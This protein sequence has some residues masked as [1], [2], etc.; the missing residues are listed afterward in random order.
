M[1]SEITKNYDDE[2]RSLQEKS[3]LNTN[4]I[5]NTNIIINTNKCTNINTINQNTN[6]TTNN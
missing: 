2:Y 3:T 1:L 5:N 6:N 4:T